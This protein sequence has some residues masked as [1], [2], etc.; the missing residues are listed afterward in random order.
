[1]PHVP[2]SCG[3]GRGLFWRGEGGSEHPAHGRGEHSPQTPHLH[4][5]PSHA[6]APLLKQR[7]HQ[8][9]PEPINLQIAEN[10]ALVAK[11]S[12]GILNWLA[13]KATF[14][15]VYFKDHGLKTLSVI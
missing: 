4:L 9:G 10:V 11:F 8:S 13:R 12:A 15:F 6:T 1:M 14:V 5:S 3:C 7:S 2:D